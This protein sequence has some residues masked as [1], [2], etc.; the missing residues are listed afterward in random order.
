MAYSCYDMMADQGIQTS[1]NAYHKLERRDGS[2]S[3]APLPPPS[4]SLIVIDLGS[5]WQHHSIFILLI[6]KPTFKHRT[7]VSLFC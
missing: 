5:H 1:Y 4:D 3:H 2:Q 6:A 7:P